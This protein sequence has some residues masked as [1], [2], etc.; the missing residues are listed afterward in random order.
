MDFTLAPVH[1]ESQPALPDSPA[2]C[3]R[4]LVVLVQYKACLFSASALPSGVASRQRSRSFRERVAVL[5]RHSVSFRGLSQTL[6]LLSWS[7]GAANLLRDMQAVALGP[8]D[9]PVALRLSSPGFAWGSWFKRPE[10]RGVQ[11]MTTDDDPVCDPALG[12]SSL[13]R[14]LCAAHIW[15]IVGRHIWCIPTTPA[16]T[17]RLEGWSGALHA[18]FKPRARLT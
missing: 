12:V 10:K 17:N 8:K 1:P 9:K 5:Y 6:A 16:A 4:H 14:Q 3:P 7:L 18:R 11:G 13:D 2:A 15:N